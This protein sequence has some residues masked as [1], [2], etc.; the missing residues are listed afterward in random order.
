[1]ASIPRVEEIIRNSG[2]EFGESHTGG[3]ID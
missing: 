2:A 3:T 1:V